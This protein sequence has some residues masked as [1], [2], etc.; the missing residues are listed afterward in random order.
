MSKTLKAIEDRH[1]D[2][3]RDKLRMEGRLN[4]SKLF[5]AQGRYLGASSRDDVKRSEK[6]NASKIMDGTYENNLEDAADLA[7]MNST[8]LEVH[9]VKA[10]VEIL[11]LNVKLRAFRQSNSVYHKCNLTSQHAVEEV[12]VVILPAHEEEK[13]EIDEAA[14][15][16]HLSAPTVAVI[17]EEIGGTVE[18]SPVES[19]AIAITKK[20]DAV[21]TIK[22][23]SVAV[24]EIVE[25]TDAAPVMPFTIL[26][27]EKAIETSETSPVEPVAIANEEEKTEQV[28]ATQIELSVVPIEED[29]EP[30]VVAI[31]KDTVE[32]FNATS[33]EPAPVDIEEKVETL[34]SSPVNGDKMPAKSIPV[35][36]NN[37]PTIS[38]GAYIIIPT[39]YCSN[40]TSQA[41][42]HITRSQKKGKRDKGIPLQI[43][44]PSYQPAYKSNPKHHRPRARKP[45][46]HKNTW[47]SRPLN[48]EAMSFIP[49]KIMHTRKRLN[50]LAKPFVPGEL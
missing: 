8:E 23:V 35:S 22:A 41:I 50:P 6:V 46:Q 27:E 2:R 49:G 30:G 21:E 18:A 3:I 37:A 43:D 17:K 10:K 11:E 24:K 38:N 4:P 39:V 1:L 7:M 48:P 15:L 44:Y 36:Y 33:F 13:P 14:P 19:I 32:T 26:M 5:H 31:V 40:F 16:P 9:Q 42:T 34:K 28:N 47:V 45:R 12:S 20:D 29:V 25:A